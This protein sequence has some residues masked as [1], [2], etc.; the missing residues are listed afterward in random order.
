MRADPTPWPIV[1]A[2]SV[3][4]IEIGGTPSR[5]N[6]AYWS[7]GDGHP[8]LSIADLSTK[9]VYHTAEQITDAGVRYS[10][11]KPVPMGT[12]VMSFKLTVGRVGLAARDM[13]TNEAI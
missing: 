3:A 1:P 2:G 13:F 8:W 12:P 10:N 4:R 7:D 6:H 11:V 5:S 9:W